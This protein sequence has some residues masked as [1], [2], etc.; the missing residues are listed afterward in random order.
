M[1]QLNPYSSILEKDAYLIKDNSKTGKGKHSKL[2][3][4]ILNDV[5]N[6]NELFQNS[7][8]HSSTPSNINRKPKSGIRVSY[9]YSVIQD[10][11]NNEKDISNL[12]DLK[13]KLRTKPKSKTHHNEIRV[14]SDCASSDE[15]KERDQQQITSNEHKKTESKDNEENFWNDEDKLGLLK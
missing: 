7:K 5:P 6:K 12:I 11:E 8:V 2:I 1:R 14:P 13:H 15:K 4:Q 10:L 9:I 3:D